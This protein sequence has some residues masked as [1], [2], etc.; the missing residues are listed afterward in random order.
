MWTVLREVCGLAAVGLTISVPL[1]LMAS[2][3]VQSFL[4]DV[5]PNDP[6]TIVSAVGVLVVASLIAGVGPARRAARI[7][8]G[9]ALRA[10]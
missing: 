4:F 10:E 8:P 7:S 5:R 9:I 2:R 3:L 6:S 1:A